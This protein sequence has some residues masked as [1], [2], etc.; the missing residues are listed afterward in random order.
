MKAKKDNKIYRI[1]E[2]QKKRYLADGY[3]IFDDEGNL[4]EYSPLKKI[5]YNRYVEVVK[6]NEELKAKVAELEALVSPKE[7]PLSKMNKSELIAKATELGL[8]ATEDMTVDM[9]VALI[10]ENQG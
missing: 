8:E 9:I 3:D 2:A 7:K 10:K 6:E 1:I 5:E 4:L